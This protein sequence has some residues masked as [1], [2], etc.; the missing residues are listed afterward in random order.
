MGGFFFFFSP[1]FEK[2]GNF[3][4]TPFLFLFKT[5]SFFPR[6]QRF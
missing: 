5:T 2:K 4:P 1:L 6:S 3:F